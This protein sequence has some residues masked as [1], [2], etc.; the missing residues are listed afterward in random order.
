MF[1]QSARFEDSS[2]EGTEELS[3]VRGEGSMI[4]SSG[5]PQDPTGRKFKGSGVLSRAVGFAMIAE[6]ISNLLTSVATI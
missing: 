2:A 6:E 4:N 1:V 3:T 5:Q